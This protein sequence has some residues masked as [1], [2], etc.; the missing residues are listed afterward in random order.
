M[1]LYIGIW[2]A[3]LAGLGAVW[4]VYGLIPVL[5]GAGMFVSGFATKKHAHYLKELAGMPKGY[6]SEKW[7]AWWGA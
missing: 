6:L 3:T 5:Y 1:K 7:S 2:L 4:Y